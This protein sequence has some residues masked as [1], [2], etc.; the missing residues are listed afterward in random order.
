MNTIQTTYRKKVGTR[1]E[2]WQKLAKQTPGGLQIKDLFVSPTTGKFVSKKAS[3]ASKQRLKEGK[4]FCKM[5]LE[6]Y[7]KTP[8]MLEVKENTDAI[9]VK[10]FPITEEY[11]EQLRL[12]YKKV[13]DKIFAIVDREGRETKETTKLKKEKDKKYKLYIDTLK[14][15]N[16]KKKKEKEKLKLKEKE[17]KNKSKNKKKKKRKKKKK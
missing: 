8:E 15:I 5:C 6:K 4:G 17:K 9:E 2:V 13:L 12:D 1:A 16:R 10:E 3:L 14:K 11:A 7:G